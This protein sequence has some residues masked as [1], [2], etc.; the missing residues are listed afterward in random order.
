MKKT[1]IQII[2]NDKI[3]RQFLIVNKRWEQM[4]WNKAVDMAG[5]LWTP[6]DKLKVRKV[7]KTA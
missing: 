7:I 4:I 5:G 3:I 2:K 1:Y 6:E